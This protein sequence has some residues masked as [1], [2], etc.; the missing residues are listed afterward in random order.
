MPIKPDITNASDA[1][2]PA[3]VERERVIAAL[4]AAPQDSRCPTRLHS[5]M[6]TLFPNAHDA[7]QVRAPSSHRLVYGLAAKSTH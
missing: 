3:A 6:A 4:V 1:L 7:S 5:E 2:W